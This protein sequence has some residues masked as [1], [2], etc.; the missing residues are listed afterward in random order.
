MTKE[1]LTIMVPVMIGRVGS[2][3]E[4][5]IEPPFE[6]EQDKL[7]KKMK[8]IHKDNLLTFL[9]K[10]RKPLNLNKIKLYCILHGVKRFVEVPACFN[11]R[12]FKSPGK[13]WPD[14]STEFCYD[15]K[16]KNFQLGHTKN[17]KIAVKRLNEGGFY[18]E[19]NG[20][21]EWKESP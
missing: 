19:D 16:F 21:G 10:K 8:K 12:Y 1:C 2:T 20:C 3:N 14:E 18:Y 9:S 17:C 13:G 6:F 7:E 4:T 11:C 5:P 15:K